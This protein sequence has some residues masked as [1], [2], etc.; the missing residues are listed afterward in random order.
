MIKLTIPTARGPYRYRFVP[1]F[2]GKKRINKAIATENLA[3][4]KTVLDAHGIRFMLYWGTLLGCMREHDFIA[5]D[6]DIDLLLKINE[7]PRFVDC[8]WELRELGFEVARFERRGFLSLIRKGEYTDFYFA[9]PLE[10]HEGVWHCSQYV[11]KKEWIEC[12]R[13]CEFAGGEYLIPQD[14]EK[15]LVQ[16]YGSTWTTPIVMF[17]YEQSAVKR[18]KSWLLQYAKVVL[19]LNLVEK[20]QERKDM[21]LRAGWLR[22]LYNPQDL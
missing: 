4:L 19:P 8:L 10:G 15:A 12:A 17:N 2:E 11:M 9:R 3:L 22:R 18:A 6:E 1:L 20:L 21:P 13:T 14:W 5:H 16:E 7:L